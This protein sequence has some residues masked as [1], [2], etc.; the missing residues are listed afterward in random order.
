MGVSGE[1]QRK[2]RLNLR[3]AWRFFLKGF[4]FLT[5]WRF[6]KGLSAFNGFNLPNIPPKNAATRLQKKIAANIG[7]L[8]DDEQEDAILDIM[9]SGNILAAILTTL[10]Y[11]LIVFFGT[12]CFN[13]NKII[14]PIPKHFLPDWD[15]MIVCDKAT[16]DIINLFGALSSW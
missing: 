9:N 8:T 4:N 5:N 11:T 16:D 6:L 13:W 2:T 10:Y 14:F 7:L 12:I 15:L 3:K 1:K